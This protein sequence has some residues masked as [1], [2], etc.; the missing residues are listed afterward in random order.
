[1]LGGNDL[2]TGAK[3][4]KVTGRMEAFLSGCILPLVF[5]IS[6]PTMKRGAWVP[7]DSFVEE[8]RELARQYAA[9]AERL[10]LQYADAAEWNIKLAYDGVHFSEEG[11]RRFADELAACLTKTMKK[12]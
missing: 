6:P 7:D 5:L 12:R 2:L 9:L 8:S 4:P 1:M 11:H 10:G 3:A